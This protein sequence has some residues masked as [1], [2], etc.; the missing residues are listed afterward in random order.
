MGQPVFP[1]AGDGSC[2]MLSPRQPHAPVPSPGLGESV[3]RLRPAALRGL[4]GARVGAARG[5][6][7]GQ[8]QLTRQCL[9]GH[10][11]PVLPSDFPGGPA[12][13]QRPRLA[14]GGAG[15]AGFQQKPA[16]T[17]NGPAGRGSFWAELTVAQP[18]A[19]RPMHREPRGSP[20]GAPWEPHT[21]PSHHSGLPWG[22]LPASQPVLPKSLIPH[23]ALAVQEGSVPCRQP[24]STS[25]N[26]A[27]P[28]S[29]WAD[30]AAPPHTGA[31]ERC[32]GRV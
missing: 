21:P 8:Q 23:P 15:S 9:R 7:W 26:P 22:W 13:S 20:V 1:P 30:P 10:P 25:P 3:P 32:P 24:P 28:A 5:T 27:P 19:P 17:R 31:G 2:S 12:P 16:R 14:A 6:A 18:D 11:A 29:R 4:G